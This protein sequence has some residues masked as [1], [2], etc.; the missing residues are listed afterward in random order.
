MHAHDAGLPQHA[1]SVA[2]RLPAK[3]WFGAELIR[4]VRSVLN[5]AQHRS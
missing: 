5:A 1:S 2:K 4:M 3:S